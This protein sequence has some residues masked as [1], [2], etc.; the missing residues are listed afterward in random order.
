MSPRAL[1]IAIVTVATAVLAYVLFIG[2]PRMTTKA[3]VKRT[4]AIPPVSVPAPPGRKIKAHLFYVGDDGTRL[5]SI[6]RD[7]TYGDSAVEQAREIIAAQIAPAASPLVS[8]IPAGTTLRAVFITEQGEAYVDLSRELSSAHPGGTVEELLTVY[9][10]VHALTENLPAVKAV[11][12]L[13]D[14]KEVE[15]LAG[16]V[17]LRRPLPKNPAWVQ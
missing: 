12:V 6:E 14:G 11:Q 9:T 13:V 7:V 8:A 16:H 5:T 17:D 15:T 10:L 1:A 4:A 2:L 3:N